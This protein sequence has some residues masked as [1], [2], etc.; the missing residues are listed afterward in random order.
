MWR[1]ID[2]DVFSVDIY[3]VFSSPEIREPPIQGL[4]FLKQQARIKFVA[5]RD[6]GFW[7]TDSA[8]TDD[9]LYSI[10]VFSTSG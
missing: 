10:G 5:V 1:T 6:H 8:Q 9:V 4:H 7:P 3:F 2:Y